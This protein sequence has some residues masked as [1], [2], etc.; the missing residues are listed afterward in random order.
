M[1]VDSLAEK[2]DVRCQRYVAGHFLPRELESI[3]GEP[4]VFAAAGNRVASF[5]GVECHGTRMKNRSDVPVAFENASRR[6]SPRGGNR[7]LR[8]GGPC[9]DLALA[10]A[11]PRRAN[12]GKSAS[13]RRQP[14]DFLSVHGELLHSPTNW[15]PYARSDD[16]SIP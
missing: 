4:H 11:V 12:Q 6:A 7:G 14:N 9:R 1:F 10:R 16:L 2:G 5:R 13:Q 8:C 3:A 15:T